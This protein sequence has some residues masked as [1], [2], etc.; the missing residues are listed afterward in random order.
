[1]N[2]L[3][4]NYILSL[5]AAMTILSLS[6]CATKVPFLSSTVV[7]AAEGTVKIKSDKNN[8]YAIEINVSNLADPNRLMPP[9][10]TYVVWL[11][12]DN[13]NMRNIGQLEQNKKLN[14]SLETISSSKPFKVFITTENNPSTQYPSTI[15]LTTGNL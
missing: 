3:I 1:M 2:N 8:N 15:V 11:G 5:A 10:S 12:I 14:A 13:N 7:P 4:K 9:G 6:S